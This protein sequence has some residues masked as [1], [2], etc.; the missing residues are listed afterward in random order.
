[1]TV[2][3]VDPSNSRALR[4]FVALERLLWGHEPMYWS[5]LDADLMKRFRG[6]SAYNREMDLGLFLLETEAGEPAGRAVGY[7]NRKWQRQRGQSAGFIGNFCFAPEAR[8]DDVAELF[9]CVEDWLRQRGCTSSICGIDGTGSLG[10]GVLT[11]DHDDRPPFPVRWHPQQYAGL[12][13]AVGYEPVRR[14]WT[15][16]VRFDNDQFR[17]A[18]SRSAK[19]PGC[20]IRAVDRG[21]WKA[22]TRLLG[23]LFNETFVDEWEMNRYSEEEF[24]E[25]W[26]SMKWVVDPRTL[27]IAEVDGEPAGFCV[28]L[29]DVS[30][31]MQSFGGRMGPFKMI[32]ML[33][34]VKKVRSHGLYVVGVRERF[35]GRHIAQT[36]ACGLYDHYEELGLDSASYYLVDDENIASR[37]VAESLGATGRIRLHCYQKPL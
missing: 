4:R 11:Q 5:E 35:R 30:P 7:V 1:M 20:R 29:P 14:F 19:E 15:Y 18:A 6:R 23:D 21:R 13:Q 2:S 10:V 26:G 36:L 22:E 12:I 31:L 17:S 24:A 32:G 9:G 16:V 34:G 27:L 3:Q 25:S 33:R 28:G 37:R 8:P